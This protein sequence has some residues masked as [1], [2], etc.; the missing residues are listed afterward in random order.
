MINSSTFEAQHSK[1][2]SPPRFCDNM[3]MLS[4]VENR[5]KEKRHCHTTREKELTK[6]SVINHVS[7]THTQNTKDTQES[8]QPKSLQQSQAQTK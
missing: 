4:R 8:K 3:M 6:K 5:K 2:M 7:R 1:G